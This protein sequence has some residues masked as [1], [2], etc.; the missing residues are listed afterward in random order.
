MTFHLQSGAKAST[1]LFLTFGLNQW[2]HIHTY[3]HTHMHTCTHAHMNAHTLIHTYTQVTVVQPYL[4]PSDSYFSIRV[5]GQGHGFVNARCALV[6][7]KSSLAARAE[8]STFACDLPDVAWLKHPQRGEVEITLYHSSH[9]LKPIADS[10][11]I[12]A[13][14]TSAGMFQR[15]SRNNNPKLENSDSGGL[16]LCITGVDYLSLQFREIIQYYLLAGVTHLYLG[17]PLWSSHPN[18]QL[19]KRFLADFINEGFVSIVISYYSDRDF[20]I[21]ELDAIFRPATSHMNTF[22]NTCS[23]H[24]RSSGDSLVFVQDMDEMAVHSFGAKTS[25]PQALKAIMD[26]LDRKLDD[27]CSLIL[28]RDTVAFKASESRW[29]SKASLAIK[30]EALLDTSHAVQPKTIHNAKRTVRVGDTRR[31]HTHKNTY[32]HYMAVDCQL[33][34]LSLTHTHTH[35]ILALSLSLLHILLLYILVEQASWTQIS[36]F[37]YFFSVYPFL[38]IHNSIEVL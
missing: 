12:T 33:R 13:G 24:A 27:I 30:H 1:L 7:H 22:I 20:E 3:P 38:F 4:L 21:P 29:D 15:V 25:L 28:E 8:C 32:S 9:G 26:R 23:L 6:D 31:T 14:S 17:V 34:A 37:T 10:F 35:T 19:L 11:F 18:Y 16:S 36:N 5:Q 2:S